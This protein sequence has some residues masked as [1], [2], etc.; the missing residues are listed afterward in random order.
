MRR[1]EYARRVRSAPGRARNSA[2][3]VMVLAGVARERH[4]LR[5]ERRSLERRLARLD[6]RLAVLSETETRLAPAIQAAAAPAAAAPAAAAPGTPSKAAPP[7]PVAPAATPEPA[8]RVA[9]PVGVT[10]VMLRY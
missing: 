1:L 6:A 3:A 4:R 10:E 5:Q 2:E 7:A 8:L 9:L